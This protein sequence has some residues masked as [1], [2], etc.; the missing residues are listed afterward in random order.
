MTVKRSRRSFGAKKK[1]S[2]QVMVFESG[3]KALSHV[4]EEM[5][6]DQKVILLVGVSNGW[7]VLTRWGTRNPFGIG[8]LLSDYTQA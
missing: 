1:E 8:S 4:E 2:L 6:K 3:D 5:N 7:A